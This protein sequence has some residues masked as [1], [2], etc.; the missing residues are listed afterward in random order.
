MNP[1]LQL[2]KVN[3]GIV[4]NDIKQEK[5]LTEFTEPERRLKS[6]EQFSEISQQHQRVFYKRLREYK[7]I[8][9]EAYYGNGSE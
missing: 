9:N 8:L 1:E 6:L 5:K 7:T 3:I 2:F 4:L